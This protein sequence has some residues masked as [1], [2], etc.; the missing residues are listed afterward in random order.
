MRPINGLASILALFSLALSAVLGCETD[1][2]VSSSFSVP[3]SQS[4]SSQYADIAGAEAMDMD[5]PDTFSS[6]AGE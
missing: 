3:E 5:T 1:Q 6:D 2:N 4:S